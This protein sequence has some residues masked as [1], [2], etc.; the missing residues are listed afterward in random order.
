MSP[1]QPMPDAVHYIIPF[2]HASTEQCAQAL[3]TLELP[4]LRALAARWALVG[5][6]DG[7]DFSLSPPHERA[8]ASAYGWTGAAGALPFAAWS[9]RRDGIDTGDLAWG[10]LTPAHWHV[11]RDHITLLDPD[12][13]A[14]NEQESRG[15]LDAVRELFESEGFLVAFGAT[16]RWYVAHESLTHLPCAS[17]DRVIGRNVDIW[18]PSGPQA[19][20]IRRLQS[21][22]QM[23][24]YRTPLNDE[25]LTRGQLEV[26]SFWLSGCG[27]Y[28]AC[29]DAEVHV[30]DSLR[31]PAL[32][33][34][35]KA[36]AQAWQSLDAGPLAGLA[37]R[38]NVTLTLCG[39]RGSVS[40]AQ[41]DSP[42]WRRWTSSLLQRW[43]SPSPEMLLGNL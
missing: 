15:L 37:S 10:L 36:W 29:S 33:Q 38:S 28:Q 13:L 16:Q 9:A 6:D 23:L 41:G 12:S 21:E 42:A 22:V 8:L 7:D 39:E 31:A 18:L 14:L 11:G 20:L 5:A 26:N 43:R 4:R 40:L 27:H 35:W 24:L 2:A 32:Q 25:R 17:I 30:L 34:D 3:R 1:F 19:R